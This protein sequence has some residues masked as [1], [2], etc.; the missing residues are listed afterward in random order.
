MF[1]L[2]LVS[3]LR[4][5]HYGIPRTFKG[6]SINSKTVRGGEL[7]IPLKG[8]KNDGHTFIGEALKRGAVGFLFERG[9]LDK[10]RIE[11]L[12]RRAFAIEVENTFE[13]LK[14]IARLRRGE[15][16][17]KGIIAVT[18]SA[19]KTTTKELIAHLLG[20]GFSVY[21]TPGNLNSRVGLPLALANAEP[22]ADY[23]V[24]ELG[25]DSR[26]NISALVD[27]L[28]PTLSVIT[29]LGKAHIE[30]FG[31]FE[32]LVS[33]K[34]EIFFP[35]TVKKAVLPKEVFRFYKALLEGKKVIPTGKGGDIEI[36]R[37]RFL[38]NGKTLIEVGGKGIEIPLLGEGI[39]KSAE[40]ALG[41]LKALELP[42]EEFLDS[43]RTFKGE[44]GRMQPLLGEGYL[45][46]NDAY[47]ANPLSVASAIRT[48]SKI[49]NYRRRVLILGDMLELGKNAKYEHLKVG[50]LIESSP[51]EAVYLYGNLT[52]FTCKAI[53][54][55]RCFYS[56]DK[57]LL[58][59]I[60]TNNEPQKGSVYLVKGSRGMK[61]EEFLPALGVEKI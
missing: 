37:Y 36:T 39:V 42:L 15:F 48:L 49:E 38:R 54:T 2:K 31:N 3:L 14:K 47:N 45:V 46:I 32:N 27:L 9:K 18:G 43:F 11:L 58:R 34:G 35:P 60:I 1:S 52:R 4:G 20:S 22:D 33:A 53:R 40:L 24:F 13:A 30:G 44:W 29:S 16:K 56:A 10:R 17:G 50:E 21:K 7:F 59:E 19:G 51:I 23:W 6:V 57:N 61:M 26:G 41:V 5:K 12:T 25:A 8:N 28:K 55:K